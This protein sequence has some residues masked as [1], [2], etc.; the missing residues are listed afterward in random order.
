MRRD[1]YREA[2]VDL[3][4]GDAAVER[5][6]PQA[7]ATATSATLEGLG[8]F[9]ALHALGGGW[10]DPVLVSATDGV[11]T[12]LL[13]AQRLGR[14]D[15]IGVDLVAMC[16]NDVAVRGAR[17]LFLLDYLAVD[18]LDPDD[19]ARIVAGIAEGCRQAGCTLAGGETAELPGLL[20]AGRFDLAGF[21]VGVVERDRLVDGRDVRPGD[22]LLGLPS[23][24]VHANGYTLVRAL[25][26]GLPMD[27]DPG[28]LG[29]PLGDALLRPTAIYA[30]D[31]RTLHDARLLRAA[32]H[33]T[34]GGLLRNLPRC[35]PA[36]CGARLRVGAWPVPPVLAFLRRVG[37]L[38]DVEMHGT[39]NGG[40]GLV[41]VV[42]PAEVDAARAAV[43]GHV[44]GEVV[45]DPAKRVVL[46]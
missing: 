8:G 30:D 43:G 28:G 38:D 27:V 22:V 10:R 1:R 36:G 34:G 18:R 31:L 4:A 44:I 33:I 14:L 29:E 19:A 9:G 24:G 32:A 41:V 40:L 11:G 39:F 12:K 17:P 7:A 35:L 25:C 3:S 13:L 26:D 6:R 16:V 23:T 5:M 15:T 2:G 37:P 20:A 46:A 21:C 42:R 45:A